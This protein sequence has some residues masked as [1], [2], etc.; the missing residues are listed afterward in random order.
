[1]TTCVSCGREVGV[2]RFCTQCGHP[3][4][5]AASRTGTA[6][7]PAVRAPLPP[8]PSGPPPSASPPPSGPPPSAPPPT[9]PGGVPTPPRFPL[10]A[11]EAAATTLTQPAVPAPEEP[12]PET[13]EAPA[14]HRGSRR[15]WGWWVVVTVVLVLVAALGIWLLTDDDSSGGSTAGEQPGGR[16]AAPTGL[17]PAGDVTSSARVEVP[18]TAPPNQDV[19][20]NTV[21]YVGANMLDGVPE[22]CWRMAGDGTGSKIVV[23]LHQRTRLR[24]VGLINGYAKTALDAQGR[25]LDW[26]HGNRRVQEVEWVFDDGTTVRQ[27]LRETTAVQSVDVDVT[28]RNVTLRLL[29]VSPPG[30]GRAARDYTAISDLLLVSAGPRG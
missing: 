22:T 4:G 3:L 14:A 1:M 20:G 19:E 7:R 28:T 10:F 2:G 16:A 11:D 30:S 29:R 8:S 12:A 13:V 17:A 18:A 6:E 21:D 23:A 26:Y 9:A 25:P 15:P 5:A 24:S 27:R